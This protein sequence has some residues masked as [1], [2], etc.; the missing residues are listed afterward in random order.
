VDEFFSTLI[1]LIPLA[2]FIFFR[3]KSAQGKREKDRHPA[4]AGKPGLTRPRGRLIESETPPGQA[5]RPRPRQRPAPAEPL[6]EVDFTPLL[7][8]I[9]PK[10]VYEELRRPPEVHTPAAE[11]PPRAE[12]RPSPAP[13]PMVPK[14]A[15]R[16]VPA[17]TLSA[18]PVL[19]RP[20][21]H[22]GLMA[23][24]ARIEGLSPWKKAVVL[25]ELLGKPKGW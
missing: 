19:G 16:P 18:I 14:A 15:D 7:E 13:K 2:F 12:I 9:L 3:L 5:D 11:S 6:R 25:A 1:Y 23:V 24:P 17:K 4:G 8:R 22:A 10:R 21:R 20:L